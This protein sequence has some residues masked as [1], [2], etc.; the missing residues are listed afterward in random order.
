M[1][2]VKCPSCGKYRK[3]LVDKQ[4]IYNYTL[5]H[6][7][8]LAH[9]LGCNIYFWHSG[10]HVLE[11]WG[12]MCYHGGSFEITKERF[13]ILKDH[14]EHKRDGLPPSAPIPPPPKDG[15]ILGGIL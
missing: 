8:Y 6:Y 5:S 13:E 11:V 7:D 1:V 14:W 15:G 10:C 9:C 4:K 3:A 12:E 2:G